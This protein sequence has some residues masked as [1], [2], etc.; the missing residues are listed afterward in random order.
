MSDTHV[1]HPTRNVGMTMTIQ[2]QSYGLITPNNWSDVCENN[3]ASAYVTIRR[4]NGATTISNTISIYLITSEEKTNILLC[5]L[6]IFQIHGNA[7]KHNES[8]NV[9]TI[10]AFLTSDVSGRPLICYGKYLIHKFFTGVTVY[11][12]IYCRTIFEKLNSHCEW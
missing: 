1:W 10:S 8:S 11:N 9:W 3:W 6:R 4:Q 5:H 7:G 2:S 12:F